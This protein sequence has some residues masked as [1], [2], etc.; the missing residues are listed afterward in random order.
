MIVDRVFSY[1]LQFPIE[2][3]A[4]LRDCYL[5][6]WTHF[7]PIEDLH[8]AYDLAQRVGKLCRALTWGRILAL[9][10]RDVRQEYA[11]AFPYWLRVFLGTEE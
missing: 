4:Y 11:T 2:T 10:S 9:L 5:Q 1:I 7:E 8:V 6:E 3:I